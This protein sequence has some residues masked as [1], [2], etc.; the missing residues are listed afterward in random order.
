MAVFKVE[1]E[2]IRTLVTEGCM[3]VDVIVASGNED[4]E[5]VVVMP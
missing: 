1:V 5:F 4:G 3:G 2:E